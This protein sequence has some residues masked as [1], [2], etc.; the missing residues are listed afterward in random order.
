MKTMRKR[1]IAMLLAAAMS[2]AAQAQDV[3]EL[4]LK[5][6]DAQL[7]LL[8]AASRKA[9]VDMQRAGEKAQVA[10]EMGGSAEI[11]KM[12]D[13]YLWVETSEGMFIEIRRLPLVNHTYVVCLVTTVEVPMQAQDSRVEFFTTD[14]TPL[15]AEGMYR[16]A[17]MTDFLRADADTTSEDFREIRAAA[18]MNLFRYLLSADGPT[19][20][21]IYRTPK[22]FNKALQ[23]KAKRFFSD[24]KKVYTWRNGRF[25]EN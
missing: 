9:L 10:N 14:W 3:A 25:E 21:V 16:P 17:T 5:M 18:D 13:D 19:L 11:W 7:V 2:V 20:S 12:T 6:P 1:W 15:P 4:F 23:E 22:Y 24:E 8:N